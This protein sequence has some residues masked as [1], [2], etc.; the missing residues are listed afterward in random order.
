M[1][2]SIKHALSPELLR[3]AVSK[4]AEVYCERFQEYGTTAEWK[5]ADRMEVQFKVKGMRL[6]GALDLRPNEISIDMDVPLPFQLFKGRAV[7]AIE[8]TVKPW[9]EQAARGELS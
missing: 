4:F 7:R 3:L 6:T 2:H 9:L 8:E 1:R 5:T